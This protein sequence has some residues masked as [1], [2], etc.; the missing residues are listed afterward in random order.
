MTARDNA[1]SWPTNA[2]LRLL[3]TQPLHHLP[4]KRTL[5]DSEDDIPPVNEVSVIFKGL[6]D[7]SIHF[8]FVHNI[9]T[10]APDPAK[11]VV[12]ENRDET[13]IE[14]TPEPA[15]KKATTFSLLWISTQLPMWLTIWRQVME[16]LSIR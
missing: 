6:P 11:K 3:P 4:K 13:D 2:A 14:S 15:P 8:R 12:A 5:S 9:P 1:R 16:F 7:W 10:T